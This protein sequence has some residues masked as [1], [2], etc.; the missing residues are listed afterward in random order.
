MIFQRIYELT[1][2]EKVTVFATAEAKRE[3]TMQ[4]A[5]VPLLFA[6]I[7]NPSAEVLFCSDANMIGGASLY[8]KNETWHK[9]QHKLT[10]KFHSK[11]SS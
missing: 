1:S 10:E 2:S 5:L 4:I 8:S 6:S 9:S 7:S 3:L 11:L